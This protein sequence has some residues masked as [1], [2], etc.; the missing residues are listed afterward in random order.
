MK[1]VSASQHH[2]RPVLPGA[3]RLSVVESVTQPVT[4][5]ALSVVLVFLSAHQGVVLLSVAGSVTPPVI[6]ITISVVLVSPLHHHNVQQGARKLSVVVT[7]TQPALNTMI[8]V[9]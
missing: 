3:V 4:S 6:S 2:N 7:V 1:T 9:G 5:T 8:Y